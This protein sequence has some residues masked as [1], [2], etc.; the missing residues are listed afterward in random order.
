MDKKM[1]R[2]AL[3][4]TLL[5]IF[6]FLLYKNIEKDLF[7]TLA[8]TFG[9]I[10]YHFVMRLIIGTMINLLLN[11]QV[12]YRK[13]W[14]QVSAIEQKLYKKLNVKKWKGKMGT[15]D[16]SCF[17]SKIHSW[18]EIAQAMCQAELVHELIIVFSFFP[19]FAAIS[20]GALPVFMLTS[21]FAACFDAMFV[22]MQRYNRPRIIKLIKNS[23]RNKNSL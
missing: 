1:K 23:E 7:L 12:N 4:S 16:P 5:T 11:N 2:I 6:S 18:D 15:Y 13:R 3:L 21:V 8:I 9:T 17:D 22:I 10:A 19:I 20:F 14:F